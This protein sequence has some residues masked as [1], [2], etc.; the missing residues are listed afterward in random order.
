MYFNTITTA[1]VRPTDPGSFTVP[2]GATDAVIMQLTRVYNNTV[3]KYR[4][5]IQLKQ[6]LKNQIIA[7]IEL[8]Y[9]K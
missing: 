7:A 6:A 3:R 1:Y 5:V 2:R 8:R 4:E 9:L